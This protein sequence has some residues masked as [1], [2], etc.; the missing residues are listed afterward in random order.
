M[1]TPLGVKYGI[2]LLSMITLNAN[3]PLLRSS[4]SETYTF[5]INISLLRNW[6]AINTKNYV[7]VF[8]YDEMMNLMIACENLAFSGDPLNWNEKISMTLDIEF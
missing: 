5:P 2:L 1:K 8:Y 4:E 3:I 7:K 6:I